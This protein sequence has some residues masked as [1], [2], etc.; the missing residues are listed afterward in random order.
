MP[1]PGT[2]TR[3]HCS[4]LP[5][6][7]AAGQVRGCLAGGSSAPG[8]ALRPLI[9]PILSLAGLEPLRAPVGAAMTRW[10]SLQA[11][12][13]HK[14]APCDPVAS[15]R[16]LSTPSL[17]TSAW[18]VQEPGAE[19]SSRRSLRGPHNR[20]LP[21]SWAGQKQHPPLQPQASAPQTHGEV[22]SWSSCGGRREVREEAPVEPRVPHG[23]RPYIRQ[24][25]LN[26]TSPALRL[27]GCGE[28]A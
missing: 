15:R 16:H 28:V 25:G 9:L 23:M 4:S 10:T 7:G 5:C 17:S 6:L 22:V 21:A 3:S 27:C 14:P 1:S 11:S 19:P 13:P 26:F 18:R 2:D 24:S 12:R 20:R 8:W